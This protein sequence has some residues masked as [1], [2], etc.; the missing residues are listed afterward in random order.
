MAITPARFDQN[1]VEALLAINT[2]LVHA[3]ADSERVSITTF[4]AILDAAGIVDDVEDY[5]TSV[6]EELAPEDYVLN[7]DGKSYYLTHDEV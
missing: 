4:E 5:M 3:M 7:N 2:T 6:Y 1:D